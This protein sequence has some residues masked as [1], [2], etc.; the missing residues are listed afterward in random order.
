MTT[1]NSESFAIASMGAA[2]RSDRDFNSRIGIDQLRA[3][4]PACRLG[5]LNRA[6]T[7]TVNNTML[8]RAG[9]FVMAHGVLVAAVVVGNTLVS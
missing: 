1:N 5:R 6:S 8:V 7:E 3:S 2:L 4:V 9:L